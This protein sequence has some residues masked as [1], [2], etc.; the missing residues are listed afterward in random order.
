VQSAI[1]QK[2]PLR[3]HVEGC[4]FVLSTPGLFT[5]ATSVTPHSREP[6]RR[7]L[8]GGRPAGSRLAPH[9]QAKAPS[10]L[11][12]SGRPSPGLWRAA[13]H[14]NRDSALARRCRDKARGWAQDPLDSPILRACAIGSAGSR[15]S[16]QQRA[17]N[18]LAA[19]CWLLLAAVLFW[20]PA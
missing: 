1:S 13:L 12:C 19:C 20:M 2:Q 3:P 16:R 9:S 6:I 4:S 15:I 7:G 5:L 18:V 8:V 11:W 10:V 17:A 14:E